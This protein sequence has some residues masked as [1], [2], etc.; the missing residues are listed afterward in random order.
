[1]SHPDLLDLQIDEYRS[2]ASIQG[3]AAAD[4][5]DA[6]SIVKDLVRDHDWTRRGAETLVE[7]AEAYGAFVL[8][9]AYALAVAI[10]KEDG[11]LDL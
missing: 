7:L 5:L 2:M 6:T 10:G 11:E 4:L 9:N 8:K 3:A 1:M